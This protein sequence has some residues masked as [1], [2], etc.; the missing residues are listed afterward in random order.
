M[1][2]L[3]GLGFS[4]IYD[5]YYS[6]ATSS[7]E[8]DNIKSQCL[9]D[10]IICV[11]GGLVNS[12]LLELVSCANC[13]SV[14]ATTQLNNPIFVGSAYWYRTP[15]RSFGFSPVYYIN[16]NYVDVVQDSNNPFRLSWY[17]G[18]E[19]GYRLGSFVTLHLSQNY[20]KYIFLKI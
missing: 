8:L 3:I 18:G 2:H 17:L 9:A 13:L 1:N 11:G 15:S 5:Y 12:D 10:S 19:G 20:K 14:L 6:H 4:L 7:V 16:Q